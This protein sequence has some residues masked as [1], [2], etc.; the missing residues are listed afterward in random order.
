MIDLTKGL[1]GVRLVSNDMKEMLLR[2]KDYWTMRPRTATLFL[3]YRCN[4]RCKTCSFWKLDAKA[5]KK[6]EIDL[7]GWKTVTDRLLTAGIDNVELFGGNVLLRKDILVPLLHYMRDRG[8]RIHM[9]T[10]QIGMDES[11]IRAIYE[12]V[13]WVYLSMDGF[14]DDLS[15][16]RGIQSANEL[17]SNTLE[18]LLEL[19]RSEPGSGKPGQSIICNTTVSRFN[20]DSLE[21]IAE[22]ACR[23]GCDEIHFEPAGEMTREAIAASSIDGNVP[24]SYFVRD[25]DPILMTREQVVLLRRRLRDIKRRFGEEITVSTVNIDSISDRELSHGEYDNRRCFVASCEATVDPAGNLVGCMFFNNFPLGS[26]LDAPFRDVW[27]GEKRAR[28]LEHRRTARPPICRQ[29]IVGVQRNPGVYRS[30]RR[31]YH[32]RIKGNWQKLVG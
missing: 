24:R 22:Y 1:K 27:L 2:E 12:C 21:Q 32:K 28:F 10:N 29:C 31:I 14:G 23:M 30:M 17:F 20:V 3:T 13:D 26:L 8:M 16:I 19:R 4:S 5:E 9:P 11:V 6:H 7:D 25:S 18:S 15:E